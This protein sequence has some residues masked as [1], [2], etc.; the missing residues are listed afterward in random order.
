MRSSD[1]GT[2]STAAL[3]QIG[4]E[5][6]HVLEVRE[7]AAKIEAARLELE[8]ILAAA[9][10]GRPERLRRWLELHRDL[11]SMQDL[12]GIVGWSDAEASE[13]NRVYPGFR[14]VPPTVSRF[15]SPVTFRSANPGDRFRI[16]EGVSAA[17]PRP[18]A[19]IKLSAAPPPEVSADT[20]QNPHEPADQSQKTSDDAARSASP[21]VKSPHAKSTPAKP[22]TAKPPIA[23]PPIAVS[24]GGLPK[25]DLAGV[26]PG[27]QKQEALRRRSTRWL[28][29]SFGVSFV[30]HVI[31]TIALGVAFY[32]ISQPPK[33]LEILSMPLESN[34]PL[35]A[36]IEM[37][38][39]SELEVTEVSHSLPA[40]AFTSSVD[41]I[42]ATDVALT[43][44]SLGPMF[45]EVTNDLGSTVGSAAGVVG[46]I[47]EMTGAVEFFG[48]T[49]AGNTFSYVV[50]NSPSMRRDGAFD[51]ARAE[52]MRSI[53][54]LKP[55]QRF[56]VSFFGKEIEA[57]ELEQGGEPEEYPVYA[58]P[59]NLEKLLRWVQSVDIQNDGWP[60]NN[61]LQQAIEME[62]D[63][64]F[65]L[66]DGDTSVDVAAFLRKANRVEDLIGGE[67]VRVP[68]H[69]IGFYTQ[70]FEKLMRQIAQENEGNYRFVPKPPKPPGSRRGR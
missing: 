43:E 37:P 11:V 2:D 47:G 15:E 70:E 5:A 52:L 21:P 49:A 63:A 62:P 66:F 48:A 46:G 41:S 20:K 29:S 38:E 61:A 54:S 32:T 8:T 28:T 65:L 64:I 27:E 22:L 26:V 68:I 44:S 23:K 60:P 13:L 25:V 6:L 58:T 40:P 56:F 7:Q 14:P 51:R 10:A 12:E 9:E 1:G 59:E 33:P 36:P 39:Q 55:T 16:D 57:M 3:L 17:E 67:R 31:L 19:A 30:V 69:T 45:S 18:A 50:D 42:A 34:E 24:K 53:T 4:R 35:D